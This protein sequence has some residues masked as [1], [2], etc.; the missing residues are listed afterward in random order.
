MRFMVLSTA[1]NSEAEDAERRLLAAMVKYNEE[2]VNAG[3]MLAG[4]GR[5]K[6]RG[7]PGSS[8]P[9]TRATWRPGRSRAPRTW[10]PGSGSSR[11]PRWRRRSSG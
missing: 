11:S 3:V 9:A 7:A 1:K 6:P 10:S 2:L 4:E 8:S 5:N